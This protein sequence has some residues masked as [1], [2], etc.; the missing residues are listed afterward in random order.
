MK[1]F[2]TDAIAVPAAGGHGV[3]LDGKH[4]RTPDKRPLVV[5]SRPLADAIAAEW[6][7]QGETVQ[8]AAM[9]LTRLANSGLDRVPHWRPAMLDEMAGFG[10]ADLLYY[11]AHAPDELVG[12]QAAAWDPPLDWARN[13]YAIDPVV[14]RGLMPVVQPDGLVLRLRA[15]L[16]GRPDLELAPIGELVGGFGSLILALALVEGELDFAGAWAAAQIDES[17]SVERWGEDAEA[18]ARSAARRRDLAEAH[19]F[20]TLLVDA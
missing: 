5:P 4:L 15:A 3:A 17:W 9:V 13:R 14:T 1:R 16:D 8:P 20:L 11:R 10:G 7:A 6:R 18:A 12:R 19:R 2:W